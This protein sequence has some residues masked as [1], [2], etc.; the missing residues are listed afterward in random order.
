MLEARYKKF[1]RFN[2]LGGP[3][4]IKK[5]QR[6]IFTPTTSVPYMLGKFGLYLKVYRNTELFW[7][8]KTKFVVNDRN[9]FMFHNVGALYTQPEYKLTRF[10]IKSL[11]GND[12]FYDVG[13]N[14]G[15]YT[16]LA[17]EFCGEVHTF[18]PL[19]VLFDDLMLNLSESKNVVLNKLALSN[20]TGVDSIHLS[21]DSGVSTINQ[22]SLDVHSYKYGK[23]LEIR[24][25]TLSEYLKN[26]KKPTVI[27]LDI[28]GAENMAIDGGYEFFKEN[29]PTIAMEVWNK[30]DGGAISMIAVEK[31]RNMGYQSYSI[32][33]DGELNKL[34]G[35][36]TNT[37][38]GDN[39]I[40]RKPLSQ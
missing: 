9:A 6:L 31:L 1:A 39:Y 32:D 7:G 34:D 36:L 3:G 8:R 38:S 23:I 14:Y 12:V 24:T 33:S 29:M 28:E 25:V 30:T 10:F 21:T 40:F 26:H 17:S 20:E 22:N 27:K 13:A 2:E 37:P 4:I 5:F 16:Y 18:E 15:F 35:D 19:P 11:M